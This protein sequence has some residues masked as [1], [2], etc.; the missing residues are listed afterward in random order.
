[1]IKILLGGF[2]LVAV[3]AA[4]T[5]LSGTGKRNARDTAFAIVASP[6]STPGPSPTPKP[7]GS[8]GTSGVF[9]VELAPQQQGL[10]LLKCITRVDLDLAGQLLAASQCYS[11]VNVALT[12]SEPPCAAWHGPGPQGANNPSPIVA[13]LG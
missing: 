3:V 12:G 5:G 1:M 11:Q 10:P 7:T 2:V 4:I 8:N 9:D 13:G 6:T